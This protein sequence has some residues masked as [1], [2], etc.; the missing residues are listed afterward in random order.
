MLANRYVAQFQ[1]TVEGWKEALNAITDSY[2]LFTENQRMW[3]Y[4]EPL[5]IGSDEVK[6][7]LPEDAERFAG[8]DT[9]FKDKLSAAWETRN[10]R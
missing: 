4:L 10:I 6:R 1:E 5:F 7:E 3:S 2:T 9:D 8:I